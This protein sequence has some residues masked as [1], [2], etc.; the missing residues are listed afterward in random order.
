MR[1]NKKVNHL[2]RTKAHREAMFAN[3]ASSLIKHKRIFT[4]TALV[5]AGSAGVRIDLIVRGICCVRPG[6]KGLNKNKIGRAHV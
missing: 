1:H 5:K 2:G 3:M 6:V 4:T